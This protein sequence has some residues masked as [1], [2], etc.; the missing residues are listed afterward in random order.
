MVNEFDRRSETAKEA[1]GPAKRSLMDW[2]RRDEAG[3]I[4]VDFIV[5]TA[6]IVILGGL[7]VGM[8]RGGQEKIAGDIDT[9]LSAVPV[10]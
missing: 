7:I 9:A 1:R 6:G 3:A 4:T 2:F 10:N 5:I 8:T